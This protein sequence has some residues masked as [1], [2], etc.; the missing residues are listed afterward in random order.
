MEILWLLGTPL[1][2][3]ILLAITGCRR[4]APEVNA[5]MSFATFIAAAALTVRIINDG[6]MTAFHEQFFIDSFNVFLVAL[7][8]FVGFTTSLFSRP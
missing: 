4:F 1:F 6:P 3:G 7:T 2:G 5:L 8:A